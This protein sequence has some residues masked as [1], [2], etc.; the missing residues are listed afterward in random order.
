L[1]IAPPLA[2]PLLQMAA[3]CAHAQW[4]LLEH[5]AAWP[6]AHV[7][8]PSSGLG[9]LVLAMLGA[10]WMLAPR[11]VPAR[12]LG[13]VLF[14]PLLLPPREPIGPG[15]FEAVFIDVGQGLSV[16]VRTREHALLYDAGARYPSEFDLGKAVVLPSLRALGVTALDRMIVSHGDNDH[17][18]GAPAIARE[19]PG[20]DLLGGEPYRGDLSL[21]QCLAGESWQWDGVRFRVLSPTP[22]LIGAPNPRGD[23]DRSCVVVVEGEGGRLLLTGDVSTR[24]EP[25]I[26]TDVTDATTPLVLAIAHHGSR[27]SSSEAFIAAVH[28]ALAIVSAGWHSRYGH[29]HPEVVA[30]FRDA[31]VPLLNTAGLGALTVG[32]PAARALVVRAERERRRRYWR[33]PSEPPRGPS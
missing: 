23:N 31:E 14:L 33:E 10:V 18:G 2:T 1:L 15:A 7:Y 19:F 9:A 26:A 29:P 25:R 12:V 6:G 17:A 22:D 5:V 11:G 24:I 28:P 13:I 21:R 8:L 30:R 4:A 27:T 32:F 3:A 20:A 16:L